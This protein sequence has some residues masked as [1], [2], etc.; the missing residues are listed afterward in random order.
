RLADEYDA[1]QE[2]GEVAA[3]GQRGKA[4]PDGNGISTAADVGL[5]GKQIFEARQIRDAIR[6]EP[7]I[8]RRALDELIASGDEPTRA[9]LKREPGLSRAN[10]RAAVGTDSASKAE[11]GNNLYQTPPEAMRALLSLMRFSPGVWE[12][13][14]GRGAICRMLED[15]G[16][17]VYLSD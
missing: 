13:A 15:A 2:R 7:G 16:Y 8:V 11:R 12:P 4:V 10:L 1:A 5:S 3:P 14:C 6:E 17:D 9:A